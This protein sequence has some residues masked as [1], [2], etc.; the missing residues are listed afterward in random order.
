MELERI[1]K[2]SKKAKQ[3]KRVSRE[4]QD[5]LL[6][7]WIALP[8]SRIQFPTEMDSLLCGSGSATHLS[9]YDG[10]PLI[11]KADGD[12]LCPSFP[13][14]TISKG[15]VLSESDVRRLY[16]SGKLKQSKPSAE[17]TRPMPSEVRRALLSVGSLLSEGFLDGS[18]R[19]VQSERETTIEGDQQLHKEIFCSWDTGSGMGTFAW[20]T[21]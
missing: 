2:A 9:L 21:G 5:D 17:R 10:S 1:G 8:S 12:Y 6:S 4:V 13:I 11:C 16:K 20:P 14:L 7:F 19:L 15:F 3:G 18:E